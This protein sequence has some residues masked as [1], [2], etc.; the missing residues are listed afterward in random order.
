MQVKLLK[1]KTKFLCTVK[2]LI[3]Y[4]YAITVELIVNILSLHRKYTTFLMRVM[5]VFFLHNAV[6]Q[7][8]VPV[9]CTFPQLFSQEHYD[10]PIFVK[11]VM[12]SMP[13]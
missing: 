10:W 5:K 6:P 12:N 11:L 7:L 2:N 9:C 3:I 8:Y 13:F 4:E 1:N